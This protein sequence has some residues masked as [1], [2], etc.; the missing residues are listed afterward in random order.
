MESKQHFLLVPGTWIGQGKITFTVSPDHLVFFTKWIVEPSINGTI[1]CEQHVEM[2]GREGALINRFHLSKIT[3][4]GFLMGLSNDLIGNIQGKGV[5]DEKTVAWEFRDQSELEGFEVYELQPNGD[6]AMH[7]EF[8]SSDNF[9][10]IVDGKI[11][12]KT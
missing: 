6:Y 8:L 7:A 1:S 3:N 4:E 12:K 2:E 10:T 11:W 9:R 5:L